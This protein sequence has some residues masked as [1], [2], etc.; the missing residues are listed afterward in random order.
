MT[1]LESLR[2]AQTK[3]EFALILGLNASFLTRTLY[4]RQVD[5]Q[6]H[7]FLI[8]KRSGG[9]RTINAPTAELKDIQS[10]L[11]VLLLDCVD[12][13]NKSKKIVP[14][15]S[16]GFTRERS[17]ITNAEKHIN[18]R[19]ILNIDL[20]DFFDSF[21]FGRVR[22]FFIKN[23]NFLLH[24]HIATVI[25]KVSCLNNSLPQGSPCSPVITNL[26]AHPLDIRLA[27]LAKRN[28]C[29]YSRYADDI[30]FSTRNKEFSIEIVNVEDCT[31]LI[32]NT[33]RKEI[34]RAGF[35]INDKKTRVQFSDSRQ[36]VTG[37]VV[38]NKVSIKSEYWRITRSMCH[39]LFITGAYIKST[40][41]GEVGGTIGELHGRLNFID[42]VDKYNRN[43]PKA[44][45]DDKYIKKNNG[46]NYRALLN[47]REKMFSKFLYY[48]S[49][50]ANNKPTILCEGK[51]D[52]IYLKSA[53]SM[54]AKQ[55]PLLANEKTETTPYDLLVNFFRY[56]KRTRYLLD[57]YGGGSYL[58][59]FVERYQENLKFYQKEI[60]I[61]PVILILDNDSGPDALLNHLITEKSKYPNCTKSKENVRNSEFIHITS[62]LYLILTP[63]IDNDESRME[64]LFDKSTLSV[65]VDGRS[66]DPSKDADTTTTYGK[67]TFATKVVMEK[68]ATVSFEGFK[69]LLDRVVSVIQYHMNLS[70]QV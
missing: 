49:F 13:I 10:R 51:T 70:A 5:S 31:V 67:N 46:L 39:K 24:E 60:P 57:L 27:S 45:I 68:K 48:R 41:S 61:N 40:S 63:R 21:N 58:K 59:K 3:K 47:V 50:Y 55:Y 56:S 6:Y 43:C 64:S 7:Q 17:I 20:S 44:S 1:R 65:L 34:D 37:L 54:L 42:S 15:L 28:S 36:D 4:I 22:G 32:G 33:L 66:F 29:T 26:I 14:K 38:N 18:R 8:P 19:N 12:E 53:I 16:H 52:N 23:S 9:F 2:K 30:T 69:P 11:S 62:N 25:A 35:K